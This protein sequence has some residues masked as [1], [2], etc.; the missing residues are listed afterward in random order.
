MLT[1]IRQAWLFC[2]QDIQ[3]RFAGSILGALWVFIWP[4]VQLFIYIIIF[5]KLMGSR[6][7]IGAS[8]N[9]YGFYIASGLLSWT[10]FAASLGRGSR[11][12]AD[13]RQLIRKASLNL[14]VLPAAICLAELLPFAAGFLLLLAAD[15]ATGWLVQ[16]RPLILVLL[17]I[18]T[19]T[20]LAY[21]LGLFLA[22]A[23]VFFRD[24]CEAAAICL[25][26][27]FWFTPIVYPTSILPDWLANLI[28]VN[29]MTAI[30]GSFQHFFSLA[31]APAPWAIA[32]SLI[33]AHLALVLGLASLCHW[34]KD[35]RDAL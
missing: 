9:A 18:Y 13:R 27:A 16:W 2:R 5:G 25:Q 29:P 10:C 30:T 19:Q 14:T 21:G 32:Y 28:W 17:A 3:D 8:G 35:I 11:C 34:Q 15:M 23:A 7:G 12:L 33:A 22:C 31:A 1:F 6:L 24:V 20:I 26:M 4:V